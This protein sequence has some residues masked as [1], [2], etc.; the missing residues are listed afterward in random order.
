MSE[1]SGSNPNGTSNIANLPQGFLEVDPSRVE[2]SAAQHRSMADLQGAIGQLD[3][4][5]P[6]VSDFFM[7]ACRSYEDSDTLRHMRRGAT[8]A[9]LLLGD[10]APNFPPDYGEYFLNQVDIS[11]KTNSRRDVFLDA[12]R[13]LINAR[14]SAM[15]SSRWHLSAQETTHNAGIMRGSINGVL[16]KAGLSGYFETAVQ[17]LDGPGLEE[18]TRELDAKYGAALISLGFGMSKYS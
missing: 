15:L 16:G 10:S 4:M 6:Q 7:G 9:R 17:N 1:F 3:D 2:A 5:S 14:R 18:P 8:L 12:E 13:E 11:R